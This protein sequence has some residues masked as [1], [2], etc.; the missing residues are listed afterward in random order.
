MIL[1]DPVFQTRGRTMN[2]DTTKPERDNFPLGKKERNIKGRRSNEN[3]QTNV[4][5][6]SEQLT[7][8]NHFSKVPDKL[9]AAPP[10]K[11]SPHDN[12]SSVVG[13][14]RSAAEVLAPP[15]GPA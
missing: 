10:L 7:R 8:Q 5:Q 6:L 2:E 4:K 3:N 9:S 15:R 12:K 11:Q 14:I 13:T 1:N